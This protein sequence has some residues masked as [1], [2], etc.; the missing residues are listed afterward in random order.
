VKV[1][2]CKIILCYKIALQLN[3]IYIMHL[4]FFILLCRTLN[5]VFFI[6]LK[7]EYYTLLRQSGFLLTVMFKALFSI[8]FVKK[9]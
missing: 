1:Y 9:F 5:C 6:Y 2:S 7:C 8:S 4:M 3:N